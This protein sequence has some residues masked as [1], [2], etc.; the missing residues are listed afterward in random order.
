MS[1]STEQDQAGVRTMRPIKRVLKASPVASGFD[2]GSPGYV[3]DGVMCQWREESRVK[4]SETRGKGEEGEGL[5]GARRDDAL[6]VDERSTLETVRR[7]E[8]SLQAS[9]LRR[10]ETQRK[11]T[12]KQ[13]S[14][15]LV[16]PRGADP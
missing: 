3:C 16:R 10:L 4:G 6:D 8:R 12:N 11:R 13:L 14:L 15:P 1:K 5:R 9:A 2:C 7:E